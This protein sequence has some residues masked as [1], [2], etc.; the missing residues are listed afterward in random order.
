MGRRPISQKC[1]YGLFVS[2]VTTSFAAAGFSVPSFA[3]NLENSFIQ[4]IKDGKVNLFIRPRYEFV[5]TEL[6]RKN[7]NALTVRTQLGAKSGRFY[8]WG[9]RLQLLNVSATGDYNS[10]QN[11]KTQ[12]A[13]VADPTGTEVEEAYLDFGDLEG[14]SLLDKTLVK[15]GRQYILYRPDPLHRFIGN[16]LWRQNWQ[17][18][19][20][21]TVRNKTLPNT[22]AHFAYVWNVNTIVQTNRGI[23]GYFVNLKYQG[24]P[25][26]LAAYAYLLDFDLAT[27]AIPSTQSYGARIKGKHPMKPTTDILYALEGTY[28][29]DFANNPFNI[30]TGYFMSEIG[31]QQKLET[32]V[33][34]VTVKFDYELLGGNGGNNRFTTPLATGHAFQ[35]TADQF[36]VTPGDGVQDFYPSIGFTFYGFKFAAV[37]HKLVS[38]NDS[39]DYGDEI[40]L[41]LSRKFGKYFMGRLKF[42]DYNASKNATNVARNPIQSN[43][44]TKFWAEIIFQWGDKY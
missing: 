18:F 29:A 36:I 41:V 10:T 8:G 28:Q 20:S 19:D 16:V 37:Y 13:L 17:T 9:A 24:L 35:G 27:A 12:F 22:L 34:S 3:E 44:I 7:A 4:A 32:V 6:P 25:F 38:V 15:G 30:D 39:Y 43:D 23:N 40:D 33:D 2:I 11:G 42:A 26:L 5:D 1:R 14:V 21:V 31:A